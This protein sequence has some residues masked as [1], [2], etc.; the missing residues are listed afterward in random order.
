MAKPINITPTLRGKAA[1][2]FY[3]KLEDNRNTMPTK[4]YLQ[5]I[6]NDA[7]ILRS[8]MKNH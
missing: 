6:Q 7:K 3:K 4:N 5:E 8:L 1:I 2:K